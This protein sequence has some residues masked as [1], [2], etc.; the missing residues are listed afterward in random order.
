MATLTFSNK[1][2]KKPYRSKE[3]ILTIHSPK[4]C[5][6]ETADTLSIDTGVTI[7]LPEKST[8][9]LTTKF[10]G[11]KIQTIEGPKKQ[12]I[13]ITLLNECYFD[14]FKKET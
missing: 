14:R 1:K 10:K 13:W 3:N 7:N 12:R 2:I 5:C 8:V 9:H 4:S 6:I 11:Q